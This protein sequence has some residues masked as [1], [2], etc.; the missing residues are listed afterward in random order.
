MNKEF[1]KKYGI[2]F[3]LQSS[4]RVGEWG[5][6]CGALFAPSVARWTN[7]ETTQQTLRVERGELAEWSKAPHC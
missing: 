3:E 6:Q 7:L 4:G 2:L 1:F 5:K